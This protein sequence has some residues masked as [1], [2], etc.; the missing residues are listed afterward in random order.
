MSSALLV[1]DLTERQEEIVRDIEAAAQHCIEN[2]KRPKNFK[3]FAEQAGYPAQI[4]YNLVAGLERTGR[5]QGLKRIQIALQNAGVK[6]RVLSLGDRSVETTA[7]TIVQ[8]QPIPQPTQDDETEVE[9]SVYTEIIQSLRKIKNRNRQQ[10]ILTSARMFF[11]IT[12][13]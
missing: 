1:L 5:I 6:T 11:G 3:E 7:V 12:A 2:N 13:V 8:P 4:L 9:I 10:H